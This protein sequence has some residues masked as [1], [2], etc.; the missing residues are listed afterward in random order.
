MQD[1]ITGKEI[2]SKASR[3]IETL[4]VEDGQ[5][6]YPEV[7]T[8]RIN[9]TLKAHGM[10]PIKGLSLQELTHCSQY[11]ERTMCHIEY[12]GLIQGEI[13]EVS[14]K[15]YHP[16]KVRALRLVRCRNIDYGYKYADRRLLN[17]IYSQRGETDEAL[18]VR[19]G[20]LTDTT[21]ANIALFDGTQ[22]FTPAHPLLYGTSRYRLLQKGK[23]KERDIPVGDIFRYQK[24]RLF[25][26][27]L[28]FGD[29][30]IQLSPKTCVM[31]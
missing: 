12:G 21:I 19:H 27:M 9:E 20:L 10:L 23:I 7:H 2:Q 16:R 28:N 26:A 1:I 3:F 5:I 15:P 30:E 25:N 6:P 24:I 8:L 29:V 13:F 17:F 14:C 22:W 31:E 18:I 4:R 11:K